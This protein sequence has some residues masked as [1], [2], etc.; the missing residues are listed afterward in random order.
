MT[1]KISVIVPVFNAETT[2]DRCLQ[3]IISQTYKNLE[4][5][6]INDGSEDRSLEI[7]YKW[8]EKDNRIKILNQENSGVS[9]SRN[10]GITKSTGKYI[11]FVDSDDWVDSEMYEKLYSKILQENADT[12][13]CR[14][15][16]VDENGNELEKANDGGLRDFVEKKDYKY[17]FVKGTNYV[18]GAIWRCLFK[19]DLLIEINFNKEIRIGEDCEFLLRYLAQTKHNVLLDEKLYYYQNSSKKDNYKKYFT[20]NWYVNTLKKLGEE[21]YKDLCYLNNVNLAQAQKFRIYLGWI[22]NIIADRSVK[23]RFVKNK[24]KNS[25]LTVFNQRKNYKKYVKLCCDNLSMRIHALIIHKGFFVFAKIYY[26]IKK[27]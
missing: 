15:Y 21:T 20:Q 4:I 19:K 14:Y 7:C 26:Y 2:L 12:V 27:Q 5:I 18:I 6:L 3:S 23:I 13:F 11:A 24:L 22:S 17:L 1:D 25:E 8:G 16:N 10:L 9:C